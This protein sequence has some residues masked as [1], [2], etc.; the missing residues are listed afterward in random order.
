M[1]TIPCPKVGG[2]KKT[3]VQT[4]AG[5]S[6]QTKQV[7]IGLLSRAQVAARLG[8]CT[9]SVQRLTRRGLL[10]AL[11]FNKRLIRYAPEAVEMFIQSAVT[12]NGGAP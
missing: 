1:A 2:A 8:L 4:S 3:A 10:P 12:S 6:P 7:L 5:L 9:H 11:V